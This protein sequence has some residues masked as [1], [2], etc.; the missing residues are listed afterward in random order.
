MEPAI[1]PATARAGLS[2]IFA[3]GERPSA[4]DIAQLLAQGPL[5]GQSTVIAQ[6]VDP[7]EGSL[8]LLASGLT[9]DLAGLAPGDGFAPPP[10]AHQF[11]MT[12]A[13]EQFRFE[14]VSLSPGLHIAG[15]GAMLPVVRTITAVGMGLAQA[16]PVKAVCWMPADSWMEPAY[17]IRAIGNW[18]EGGAF[19]ALGFTPVGP[20]ARG[21]ESTGLGFFAG[22]EVRV[23]APAGQARTDSVQMAVRVID[24]IMRNGPMT[25]LQHFEGVEGE[26]MLAE[27]THDGRHVQV[28]RS[29]AGA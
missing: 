15:G 4:A 16:L 2:L 5:A 29:A 7:Y 6:Q 19:P 10:M 17:F 27:P 28:W 8:E 13:P 25:T 20:T 3:E 22:Q 14:S 1:T 21:V 11:G 26:R 24:H 18:L 9:F 12:V 23:E